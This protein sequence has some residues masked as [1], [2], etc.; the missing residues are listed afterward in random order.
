MGN[1]F[2]ELKGVNLSE[3]TVQNQMNRITQDANAESHQ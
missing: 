1:C 2:F 3:S